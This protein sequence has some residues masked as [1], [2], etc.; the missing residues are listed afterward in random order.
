MWGPPEDN[1]WNSPYSNSIW[2]QT[3]QDNLITIYKLLKQVARLILDKDY[4]TPSVEL[5]GELQWVIFPE[6][7][8]Y[9]QAILVYKSLN[10][11]APPYMK[12]IFQY[13][14]DVFITL[15]FD[16]QLTHLSLQGTFQPAGIGLACTSTQ[17]CSAMGR[18]QKE[19]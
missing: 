19:A 9:H 7:V 16:Q 5:F 2:D 6:S 18:V 15:T 14:K 12:N 17:I 1:F 11:L 3:S 4:N 13:V 8:H 10:N